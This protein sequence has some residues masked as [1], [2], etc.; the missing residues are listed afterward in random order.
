M[1]GRQSWA[2][3]TPPAFGAQAYARLAERLG[4]LVLAGDAD[5]VLVP[6]EAI[7]ALEAVARELGAGGPRVLN[8]ATSQYGY[9]FGQ[10]LSEEGATVTTLAPPVPGQPVTAE[11]VVSALAN[12]YDVVSFVHGE[13]ATGI[14]NPIDAI[15]TQ[16]R[17]R[18]VVSVVDAVASVGAEP[19]RAGG[20]TGADIVVLGPQK[21]LAGPA[22]ISAV[23]IGEAGWKA[24]SRPT[25]RVA[26]LSSVSL[27]DI[28]RD[29]LDTDHSAIPG[30][31]APH[32]LWAL[33]AA[34]EA[35][36]AEGVDALVARHRLAATA[37]RAGVQGLGLRPWADDLAQASGLVTGLLLPE[38]ADRQAV[39]TLGREHFGADL[40]A[41]PAGTDEQLVKIRHTGRQASFEAVLAG[42]GGL[43][44]A[45]SRL[46]HP[47]DAATGLAAAVE[48]YAS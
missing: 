45:L 41:A 25:R 12:G 5:T 17:R 44:G 21:A 24:L 18:G 6:G 10:W 19:L 16:A 43:A 27:L 7:V 39:V 48:V 29:W 15:V 13:A 32:E 36:G 11:Q 42:L 38:G 23:T 35:V 46:G 37:V 20:P 47:V 22:G 14:V 31:P 26:T 2:W 33:E 3:A 30:T 28:R 40:V 9:L 4:E 1:S 34:L 8:V